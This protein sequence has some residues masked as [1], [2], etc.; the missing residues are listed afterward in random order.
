[1]EEMMTDLTRRYS[2]ALG[3]HL[4]DREVGREP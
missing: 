3:R 4:E 2:R 1:M